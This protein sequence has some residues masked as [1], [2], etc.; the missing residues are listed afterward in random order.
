MLRHSMFA[1]PLFAAAASLL[2][3]AGLASAQEQVQ[4]TSPAGAT[5]TTT[6]TTPGTLPAGGEAGAV[7]KFFVETNEVNLGVIN[8]EKIVE[9]VIKFRNDG[10]GPLSFKQIKGSCGCTV[11]RIDEMKPS[12]GPGEGG[13]IKVGYNPHNRNGPQHTQVTIETNDPAQ[14]SVIVHIKSEVRPLLRI[15]PMVVNVGRVH[16]DSLTKQVATI[17]SRIPGLKIEQAIPSS[18][19]VTAALGSA[20]SRTEGSES[21]DATPIEVMVSPMATPGPLNETITIRT[22]QS[23]RLL[24]LTVMGE[25]L[26]DIVTEPPQL[27][28][29][30]LSPGQP[31][32]S[33][34]RLVGRK[35][36]PFQI[37][38]VQEV[39]QQTPGVA[40]QTTP[41]PLFT[42]TP[43]LDAAAEVP[44]WNVRLSGTA[45]QSGQTRGTIVVN[46]DSVDMPQIR[47]NYF[48][49]VR[50]QVQGQPRDVWEA[51]PSALTGR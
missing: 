31:I 16:K 22:S 36:K 30:G 40:G 37:T 19:K 4:T 17:S 39:V 1:L 3:S 13:E 8:D 26:G 2:A 20:T 49:F 5:A 21:I 24:T 9:R 28:F 23:D 44:T 18:A 25:V 15:D 34:F 38:S 51:N 41:T 50:Q 29:A 10:T 48:G 43:E 42:V 47:V 32:N 33:Q 27:S 14:P 6:V 11:P 7:A 35:D 45:P 12:Y 46:T